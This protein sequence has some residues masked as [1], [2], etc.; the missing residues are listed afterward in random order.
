MGDQFKLRL[1]GIDPLVEFILAKGCNCLVFK[2]DLCRAYRQFRV[3][4]RYYSLLGFCFQGQFYFDTRCP[5]GLRSSAMI[6]QHTTK[7][8]IHI[9]NGQAFL[10]DVY[11]DDFYGAEYL[12]LGFQAFSQL[13]QLFQQLGLD[14]SLKRI[15]PL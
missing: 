5:F 8:I 6:C 4:P 1:P 14:S 11:L 3:D 12:S 2:K 13:G 10:A 9:F 7:T 15:Y